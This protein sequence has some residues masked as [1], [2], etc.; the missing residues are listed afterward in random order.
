M[1][2]LTS[3]SPELIQAQ[4]ATYAAEQ[5]G[6]Y[7][8]RGY[9]FENIGTIALGS[10][11]DI[12][13]I[14]QDTEC[15]QDETGK[16]VRIPEGT[17][18]TA[19]TASE[20][21]GF[22]RSV[23]GSNYE[24]TAGRAELLGAYHEYEPT[25]ATLKSELS[26]PTTRK[27]HPNF[28]GS[29]SNSMVF[30]ISKRDTKF[31]VRVPTGRSL[32][33][34]AIDS[35]LGG[36]VLG[37]GV[38]HLEQIVAASYIEG[39]TI[40]E[41]MPG[42]EMGDL[43]VEEIDQVTDEQLGELVDTLVA[44]NK[45]GIEIDPK[46]SNMFY[47]PEQGYGIVDYHSSKVAGKTTQDQTL[48]TIVGWM[49]TGIENAG[50]YGKPYKSEKSVEDF[51][52][53]VAFAKANYRVL[54]RYRVVVEGKLSGEDRKEALKQIDEKLERDKEMVANPLWAT[55]QLVMQ[56]EWKRRREE[57]ARQPVSDDGWDFV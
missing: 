17:L 20:Y 32:D 48:G 10:V 35:H 47:D 11:E 49:S 46:P 18:R 34:E 19:A 15:H 13:R 33:P 55:E 43:T 44:V 16:I 36:A 1:S 5:V 40:A 8:D 41:I 39:V 24:A 54:E 2:E 6:N 37:K 21:T 30:S 9:I 51:S 42:K 45:R 22:L 38:P 26:D 3:K 7:R 52:E 31:A 4:V 14:T 56:Q 23:G 25:V 12:T 28:L 53:D 29:G 27:G 57:Q 50:R